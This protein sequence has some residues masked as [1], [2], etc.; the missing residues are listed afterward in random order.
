MR[1]GIVV[2]GRNEAERLAGC[3]ASLRGEGT[4]VVYVDSGST[5]DSVAIARDAGTHVLQLNPQRPF[6]AARARNE[7]VDALLTAFPDIDL[8][9]FL[10]GDCTLCAGWI[11]AGR[12][13]LEADPKLA[14]V[15][16]HVVERRPEASPYNRLCAL[17]W[18]SA[19]GDLQQYDRLGGISMMRV[20]VFRRLGGFRPEVIAGEDSELGVRMAIAGYRVA[21]LDCRMAMHDANM[22]RFGQ[23]WRRAVRAGHAIGQRAHLNGN[24][25]V[26]DCVRER[27]S[28]LFWGLGL[29]LA[30]LVTAIPTQ[31]ASLAFLAGYPAL[32]LRIALR[33]RKGGDSW[34]EARLYAIFTIIGKFANAIGLA[35]F[36]F[37]QATH[38]YQIIEYK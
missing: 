3:F 23:W 4:P 32:G 35:R 13:G 36:A 10:D 7:G 2:I 38:R 27:K 25:A 16:G 15:V 20:D 12:H 8:V 19:P 17:E 31:G 29:P 33:R 9:Q 37:N 34:S 26:R 5:D 22:T 18:R 24:S 14:A 28:T 6:S 11:D 1:V 30:V 21:K